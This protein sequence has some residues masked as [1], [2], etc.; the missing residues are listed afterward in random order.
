MPHVTADDGA[1]IFYK[2]WG[3]TARLS[4]SATDGP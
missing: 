4:S 3:A 2:D 1:E